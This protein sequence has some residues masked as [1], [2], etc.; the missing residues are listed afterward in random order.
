MKRHEAIAP[1]S[2]EHHDALILS[3]LLKLNA[4]AYRGMPSTIT[5]KIVYAKT[6]YNEHLI[7]HFK[8]EEALLN[9]V[10]HNDVAIDAMANEIRNEH[11]V[12]SA[13]FELLDVS[14][15]DEMQLDEIGRQLEL[16]IRKEERQLFP[17]IEANCT[18]QQFDEIKALLQS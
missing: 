14:I 3:Q 17:M 6:F 4:P 8:Q 7:A 16:H 18:E 13:L 2:R 5:D 11:V 10:H 15:P 1:L 9:I 12:L